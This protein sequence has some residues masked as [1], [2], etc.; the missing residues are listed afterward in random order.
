M[1]ANLICVHVFTLLHKYSGF[2]LSVESIFAVNPLQGLNLW[3]QPHQRPQ[4][5]EQ[6]KVSVAFMRLSGI[7]RGH[8]WP[9]GAS[10]RFQSC[11]EA[12][13]VLNTEILLSMCL[14]ICKRS[15]HGFWGK[16]ELGG[17]IEAALGGG[18]DEQW[19]WHRCS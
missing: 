17:V 6:N 16:T 2:S 1:C 19:C 8:V 5:R 18:W 13:I 11:L 12:Q 15:R 9:L 7:H 3:L 4:R 10:E 14:D